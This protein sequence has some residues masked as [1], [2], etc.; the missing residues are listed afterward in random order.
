MLSS[1][2]KFFLRECIWRNQKDLATMLTSIQLT[3]VAP[4]VNLRISQARKGSTLALKPRSDIYITG[5]KKQGYQWSHE[6]DLCPP[7]ILRKRKIKSVHISNF[8]CQPSSY[9]KQKCNQYKIEILRTKFR[10]GNGIFNK[11]IHEASVWI[12]VSPEGYFRCWFHQ[13]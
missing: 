4:E 3:G 7:K 11:N 5:S 9:V 6:K 12:S 13:R 8:L 1:F 2:M 10:Q